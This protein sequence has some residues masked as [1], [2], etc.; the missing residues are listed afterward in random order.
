MHIP[1]MMT[2]VNRARG[3]VGMDGGLSANLFRIDNYTLQVTATS[4]RGD[5]HPK[6]PLTAADC[7]SPPGLERRRMIFDEAA[8]MTNLP[9][10]EY[11]S[12]VML[13]VLSYGFISVL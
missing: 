7:Y 6:V 3:R 4:T 11:V 8:N 9:V 12:G 1:F 5:I 2:N 10:R 13:C